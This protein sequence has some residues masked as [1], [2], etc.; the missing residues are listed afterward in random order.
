[1]RVWMRNQVDV[2]KPI[3]LH[4]LKPWERI[5]TSILYQVQDLDLYKKRKERENEK[6]FMAK[7]EREEKLKDTL[8]AYI[9]N[10]LVKNRNPQ[11]RKKRKVA[12]KITLAIDRSFDDVL[13]EVL[14]GKDFVSF[15]I[16]RI[17]E[18]PDILL[19]NPSLPIM[20]EFSKK[21]L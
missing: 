6:A 1:M 2:N 7:M 17:Q 19:A 20:I 11:I 15:N 10:D 3:D 18:S 16:R 21:V 5:I 8:L 13:D 14:S 4:T 9:Y 12:E